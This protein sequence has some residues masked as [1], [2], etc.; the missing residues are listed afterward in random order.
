MDQTPAELVHHLMESPAS[1][2][3]LDDPVGDRHAIGG[4]RQARMVGDGDQAGR[5]RD[6][7][8][9][10]RR[11]KLLSRVSFRTD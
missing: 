4:R 10:V 3:S 8:R 9:V 6:T 2:C 1:T 11:P 7:R 5:K